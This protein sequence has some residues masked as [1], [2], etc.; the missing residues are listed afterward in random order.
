MYINSVATTV[1]VPPN[2]IICPGDTVTFNCSVTLSTCGVLSWSV[3]NVAVGSFLDITGQVGTRASNPDFPGVVATIT[4]V[5]VDA[6]N[7]SSSLTISFV[8]LNNSVVHGSQILCTDHNEQDQRELMVA[9]QFIIASY[10]CMFIVIF[11]N[12]PGDH[13]VSNPREC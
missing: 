8:G 11:S 6:N 3:N 1:L 5:D 4:D 10:Y 9:S 7:I 2:E 12:R 13:C